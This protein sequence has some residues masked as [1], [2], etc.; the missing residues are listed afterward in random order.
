MLRQSNP[1]NTGGQ[2][3]PQG[4]NCKGEEWKAHEETGKKKQADGHAHTG[5]H[6]GGDPYTTEEICH[7][8]YEQIDTW[9]LHNG[10]MLTRFQTKLGLFHLDKTW[11]L[12]TRA[13][14]RIDK[15]RAL[16]SLRQIYTP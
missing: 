16:T 5:Q 3:G 15:A 4:G 1:V 9:W 13:I 6:V 8:I 10:L 12:A 2:P 7:C 14:G 11:G